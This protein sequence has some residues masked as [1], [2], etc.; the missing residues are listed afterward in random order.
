MSRPH[1][2]IQVYRFDIN[3]HINEENKWNC[4]Y[5]GNSLRRIEKPDEHGNGV[6]RHA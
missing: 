4:V 1:I 2:Q 3:K 5:L 6:A